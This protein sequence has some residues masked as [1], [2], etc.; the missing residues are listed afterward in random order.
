MTRVALLAL[1]ALVVGACSRAPTP[2]PAAVAEPGDSASETPTATPTTQP[3]PPS[4]SPTATET[5]PSLSDDELVALGVNE[6]GRVPV[7]EWHDVGADADGRWDNTIDTFRRQ[8]ETLYERGFRPVTTEEFA[9]GSFPIPAG[10]SPVLLTFDD[11]YGS[12]LTFGPDG[13]PAP[14]TAVGVLEAFAEE[15]PDWRATGVFYIYWP[16]PFRESGEVITEKLNW[17]VDNGYEI[18]NHT[19]GHDD[20][21]AMSDAEVVETLGRAQAEIEEH[22]PGYRL[23][24][25]SLTFGLWP[26][27]E[28]LAVSGEW[29]GVRYQHD[30][31]MLVG[32]MPTRSPHHVEY[33][34]T[35]VQRVQAY[36][37]EFDKWMAWL[38]EP[39]R[40]FISDGDPATV[41]YPSSFED[42]ARPLGGLEVRTYE[43]GAP[44]AA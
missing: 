4:P 8:I 29:N 42:V 18:G 1:A 44:A 36:V 33:D 41:T 26:E 9:A 16:I 22:V 17:L 35:G 6:I 15:H 5:T 13:E 30:L 40:R 11:S 43:G 37:P 19:F 3:P 21:S 34:P 39:G 27:N 38:D 28:A 23:R 2:A 7:I 24:T 10:T 31:V 32:F 20:M 12:H 25:L 14:D